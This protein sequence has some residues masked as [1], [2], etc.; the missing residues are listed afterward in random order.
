MKK[1]FLEKQKQTLKEK[2]KAIEKEL[3]SFAKRSEHNKDDW[4]AHFPEFGDSEVGGSRLEVAQDEVEEYLNRLPV[5]QSLEKN[6][7]DINDALLKIKKGKYGGCEGCGKLIIE[8]RLK[9][10]PEAR[11]CLKCKP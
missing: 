11:Y 2:A 1:E 8:K 3:T 5:E 9:V 7:Q 4:K 10:C 6:L